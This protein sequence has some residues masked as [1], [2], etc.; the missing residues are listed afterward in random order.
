M[1]HCK[2]TYAPFASLRRTGIWTAFLALSLTPL[3]AVANHPLCQ[4]VSTLTTLHSFDGADGTNPATGLTQGSDGNFYGTTGYGGTDGIGT[5]FKITPTGVLTSL[6]SFGSSPTD[7]YE[8]FTRL[9]QGADGDFYG[10]TVDYQT[11]EIGSIFKVSAA[12]VFTTLHALDLEGHEGSEPS[13][14]IQGSDG[15]FYGTTNGQGSSDWGTVFKITPAGVLTTLHWFSYSD[16]AYP[17]AAV[18]EGS[19]GN[20]YGT[21][22]EG[23]ASSQGTVFKMTPSGVLTTLH[24]FSGVDGGHPTAGLIVGSDGSFYGTTQLGGATGNGTVFKITPTNHWTYINGRLV[25]SVSYP[26]TTLHSFAG[27]GTFTVYATSLI[28]GADGEFYGTT[29][30]NGPVGEGTIFQ[31]GADGTFTTLYTFNSSYQWQPSG[32]IQGS[33]GNFYGTT[34]SGGPNDDGTVFQ[35]TL[36][37]VCQRPN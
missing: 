16:G 17:D 24:T 14:L 29:A 6:H 12:G 9:V 22:F 10:T 32:L 23:G 19:D 11:S 31:M 8:P 28:Q 33:D 30:Y 25:R 35:F 36:S 15:N 2:S 27:A 26:L 20:F 13:A 1:N 4:W 3:I 34:R 21:T 18:V 37:L 7:G 5:V